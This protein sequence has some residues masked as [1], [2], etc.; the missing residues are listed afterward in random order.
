LRKN[1]QGGRNVR[2]VGRTNSGRKVHIRYERNV[3]GVGG[4]M[5]KE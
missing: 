3:R 1:V 4:T 2:C 5:R